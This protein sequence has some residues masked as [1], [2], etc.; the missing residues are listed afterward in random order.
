MKLVHVVLRL[1]GG[2]TGLEGVRGALL[3]LSTAAILMRSPDVST[4]QR[5]ETYIRAVE[6]IRRYPS[7]MCLDE[8]C[9][10]VAQPVTR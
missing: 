10:I 6:E 9:S 2:L 8:V 5:G 4:T 3:F 1:R 7:R